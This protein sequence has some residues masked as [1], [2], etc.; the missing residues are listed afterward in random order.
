MV[1]QLLRRRFRGQR[2]YKR[3]EPAIERKPPT[4]KSNQPGPVEIFVVL[5]IHDVEAPEEVI[6]TTRPIP[7]DNVPTSTLRHI[8]SPRFLIWKVDSPSRKAAIIL[9]PHSGNV[10]DTGSARLYKYIYHIPSPTTPN[11]V[12]T[13]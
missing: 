10:R 4:G 12:E 6:E 13:Q 2:K 8:A 5:P 11:P 9:V 1:V 7:Y 3:A